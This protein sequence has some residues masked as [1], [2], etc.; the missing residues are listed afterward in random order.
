MRVL[1]IGNY[2]DLGSIY[3]RCASE[4]HDA[5]VFVA[6]EGSRDVLR[7]LVPQETDLNAAIAWAAGGEH[8][9][10]V[11]DSGWGEQQDAMRARGLHVLGSSALG[12]RLQGGRA[13][14][15]QGAPGPRP[16]P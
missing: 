15:P 2:N 12:D 11:E 13:H 10:L 1:G 7:G 8:V 9:I 4:G 5:R 6:E 14:C 16:P 3:M